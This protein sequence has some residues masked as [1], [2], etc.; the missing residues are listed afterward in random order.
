MLLFFA[1]DNKGEFKPVDRPASSGDQLVLSKELTRE[2]VA[3]LVETF[4]FSKHLLRDVFDKNELPRIEVDNGY[5]YI[6][7][8]NTDYTQNV[9]RTY[10]VLFIIGKHFFACLSARRRST[11]YLV[12]IPSHGQALPLQYQLISGVLSVVKNYERAL[13]HISDIILSTEQRM[14]S[15]E[16][17]NNDF[18]SFVSIESSLGRAKTSLIGLSTVVEKLLSTSRTNAERE[19]YD[20]ILLFSKQLLVEIDSNLRTIMSIRETYGTVANNTLNQ[21]MKLL[22]ALTLLMA[23]PNVFYSMYGMNIALPFMHESWAYAV[24]VIFTALLVLLV[25]VVARRKHIF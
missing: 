7:L 25:Y 9:I 2:D 16:V 12:N 6:F 4:G 11:E 13:D 15:H 5:H 19:L 24:I 20:D 17:N 8:R 21:R 23:L 14:Q 1:H 18:Y 22:T 3:Q 10:P